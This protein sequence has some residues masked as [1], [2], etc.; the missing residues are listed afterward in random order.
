M[1]LVWK[2]L[3]RHIS[4]LQL[5][6]FFIANLFGMSVVLVGYQFYRD[7]VPALEAPDSFMKAGYVVVNKKIGSASAI[8]GGNTFTPEEIEALRSQPFV[9]SAAG[10]TS[11]NYKA[12][13]KMGVDGRTLLHSEIFYESVPDSFVDAKRGLWKYEPGDASVPVILP[14]AYIAMYN[15]GFARNRDLPKISDGLAGLIDLRIYVS[16]AGRSAE[17]VGRVIGFSSKLNTV[18]VPQGFADWTN[19]QYAPGE[20]NPPSRLIIDVANPAD[21]RLSEYLERHGYEAEEGN[22][23]A[24]KTTYFLRL[25]SAMVM[26]VGGLVSAL[27]F[28][29][30]LLSIY[31]LVQKNIGKIQNLLLIGYTPAKAALPYQALA[32]GLNAAVLAIALAVLAVVRGYYMD[33]LTT[34]FPEMEEGGMAGA[35]WLGAALFAGVTALNCVVIRARV[36]PLWRAKN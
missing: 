35:V 22:L 25:V 23:D 26:A 36:S 3:R 7:L 34:L 18:L 16:G 32:A 33:T 8:G 28:Y 30:L 21:G 17:Y 20:E 13:A 19:G 24:E 14:R 1:R 9:K 31:L 4:A 6:G 29:I 5:A 12:E 15:F 10:F 27:S 11:A 2:L